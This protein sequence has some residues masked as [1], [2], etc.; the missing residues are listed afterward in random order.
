MIET[1][2]RLLRKAK[3][4]MDFAKK[5]DNFLRGSGLAQSWKDP[6]NTIH[7]R[8]RAG[9]GDGVDGECDIESELKCLTCGRLYANAGGAAGND[10]LRD[11]QLL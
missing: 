4:G 5:V 2:M 10:D 9:V 1:A 7:M 8:L 11:A 3:S 6:R